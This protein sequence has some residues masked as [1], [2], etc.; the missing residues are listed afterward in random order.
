MLFKIEEVTNLKVLLYW[1]C[2]GVYRVMG[3]E[4]RNISMSYMLSF[5]EIILRLG[6]P[7]YHLDVSVLCLQQSYTYL[8]IPRIF[9]EY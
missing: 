2:T 6:W 8:H 7:I 4:G 9:Q 1:S 3:I 5:S